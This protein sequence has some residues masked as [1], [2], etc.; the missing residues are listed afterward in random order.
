MP[1][2]SFTTSGTLRKSALRQANE[3]LVLDAIRRNP[4]ISRAD[5][6]RSTGFSRPSVTFVVN[7][8]IG[9]RLVKDVKAEGNTQNGR[10]PTALQIRPEAKAAIGVEIARPV[11]R[12]ALVDLNGKTLHAGGVDWKP[13]AEAFLADLGDAIRTVAGSRRGGQVLGVGVSMPGT[14]DRTSGRVIAAEALGW[15]D[16]EVGRILRRRLKWPVYFENDANLCAQGEQWYTERGDE[17]LRY[18]VYLHLRSGLGSGVFVDG[19]ML[20]GVAS[21]AA[22]F[23]HVM[24]YPGGRPCGCGNRGCWEQ[25]ASGEALVREYCELSKRT[26]DPLT[27][28]NLA[29]D[30]DAH[31]GAA[32][33]TTA[34]HLGLGLVNVIAALNPQAI[35]FGEPIASAWSLV[36]ATIG[37]ELRARVPAYCL[38]GLRLLPA[39]FGEDAGLR[40]ATALVLEHFFNRFDHSNEEGQANQVGDG[41]VW[42]R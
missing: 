14:I 39:R 8:L 9:Q 13:D 38:E 11:S 32:L 24:L 21:A 1:K 31:A 36:E 19:R 26:E 10:P 3:R 16:V 20:H 17:P 15:F 33:Q 41:S 6:A 7:R 42:L 5:I 23:G 2:V 28:V 34:A 22:E 29:R 4:G 40:G 35:I 18:F 27:I 37:A 12:V 25:Y 30:G